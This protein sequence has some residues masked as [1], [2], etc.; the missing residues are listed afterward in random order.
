MTD[1][2]ASLK[3]SALSLAFAVCAA[4][5]LL[6]SP[7]QAEAQDIP[8]PEEIFGFQVGADYKLASYPQMMEYYNALDQ[9]SDRVR[10]VTI[11]ESTMGRPMVLLIISSEENMRQLDRWR[12]ISEQM[13]RARIPRDE[14]EQLA[15]EGKAVVWL[16]GGMHATEM[17][18]GQMTS[19]LAWKVA[20]EESPEM[21][22]IRENV[23]TLIMPMINPDGLEIV[24][25]WYMQTLDT[26]Y[27]DSGPPW[28]YQKY[29]GH[30]NNRDWF[31]NNMQETQVVNRVLY[32]EWYPQVVYNHHQTAPY[33]TRIF[34]PPFSDPVNPNIHPGVTSGVNMVGSAMSQR[35]AVKDM[36]GYI[37]DNSYTMF[38]N[39]G[40]RTAP[41]YH[42]MIG[43]L[44]EVAHPS[45][46]P[47]YYDPEDKPS[48]VGS[49]IPTDGTDIFYPDPWE[50]GESHFRDAVD[51]M[52]QGSMAVLD[53]A[54]E[55][56]RQFL[57]NIYNMGQDAITSGE[58]GNPYA[59]VI[60]REQ[61]DEGEATNMVNILMRDGI[62]IHRA[63]RSFSA[64]DSTYPA[65][66]WVI[67]A[68]Q[69]YQPMVKDMLEPQNYPTRYQYPGGPP[70]PP[71]DLA[72]WTLPMQ[73]GVRV[74]R[75]DSAFDYR[76]TMLEELQNPQPGEISGGSDY[77]FVLS[78]K[79]NFSARAMNRL[80]GDG[81]TL[82]WTK[83]AFSQG[84]D[85]FEAGSI[86]I[87]N[88][89][90]SRAAV[91]AV[92]EEMGLD[93]H[94]LSGEPD[95]TLYEVR[96]PR[97]GLYKSWDASMDE[98][99]TRWMLKEYEFDVDTLHNR[100]IRNDDLSRYDAIILP[101]QSPSDILHGED[102]DDMP[103]KYVGGIE[104]GGMQ[105]LRE[106]VMEGGTL[107]S[108]DSASD[109]LIEQFL[110][111]VDNETEGASRTEFFIPG[112][113]IRA[114]VDSGNPLAFGMQPEVAAS[115]SHSRSFSVDWPVSDEEDSLQIEPPPIHS[116]VRYAEEDLLMSGW[117][118]GEQRY[119]GGE[120]AMM[121]I[122]FG[123]GNL[124]MY[125]FRPQFRGQP[126]GTYK[127]IFNP[128]FIS[129]MD[130][131]FVDFDTTVRL[132]RDDN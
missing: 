74:D 2:S 26:P 103:P 95:I 40:G 53:I 50:G 101:D 4:V 81:H 99:W 111:P 52:I 8:A 107:L 43:I 96:K 34:L 93:F 56:K 68:A 88:S 3:R 15:G 51:Y 73:M 92:A 127:L 21:R 22:R 64:G 85:E 97:V 71:Y 44:T 35:F 13:S 33:W 109:L 110:L 83:E 87:E 10:M 46:T 117:A 108:F 18:H 126:R 20:A 14:A 7:W 94:G 130:Q 77:G 24:R 19:E 16:D 115:F 106:Y 116:P 55:R 9:A 29:V 72:G 70:D 37:S 31:M 66:T 36:P 30:D 131:D 47:D 128:L 114:T 42:N 67:E 82:Y 113:L 60:P 90:G 102:P 119:L 124:V 123:E 129:T 78:H 100:N 28:L 32:H 76:G 38:W 27:Q 120:S 48:R 80:L 23:I 5:L 105:A 62:E 25:D 12:S 6:G 17:A 132:P 89:S 58:E 86:V 98:G 69:A 91:S 59:Y 112:S 75:V 39:G 125:A 104:L 84:G 121:N 79:P 61:W 54:A 49:G 45:P 118:L 11:G 63:D 1:S 65:G 57:M 41:Y 122:R